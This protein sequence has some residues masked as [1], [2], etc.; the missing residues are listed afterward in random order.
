MGAGHVALEVSSHALH[1]KRIDGV[2]FDSVLFTNLSRDHIDYHG[3]MDAYGE[4]KAR[5]VMDGSV[6]HRIVTVDSEFGRRLANRCADQGGD[7]VIA[8]STQAES[9][10][11]AMPHV[12]MQ[13]IEADEYGSRVEVRSSWGGTRLHLPLAGQFN[14]ANG[15]LVLAQ[16]LGW[17][18]PLPDAADALCKVRPP[19]G[20]MQRVASGDKAP[21]PVVY[22]DYAHT[23]AG[24]E[25]VLGTLRS[26]CKGKL[27]CVF[28]C[29]GDRDQGKRAEMGRVVA[30]LADRPVV[31]SDNPRNEQPGEIIA[32]VLGGMAPD[33]IA[34]EDREAAI[35]YAIENADDDDV[36]LI[37]GKGHEDYQVIHGVRRPFSDY[38]VALTKLNE[39]RPQSRRR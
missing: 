24:L 26:H 8:V 20:R 9:D 31:T 22:I 23:P 6:T 21:V 5:F 12:H 16:L 35:A 11:V 29:G 25:A 32:A 30:R 36:I 27:W 13:L 19:P 17:E 37:A 33:T 1:Q 7:N 34:L 4:T 2:H 39:R 10:A 38:D 15:A 3:D 18:I 14:V 28:G